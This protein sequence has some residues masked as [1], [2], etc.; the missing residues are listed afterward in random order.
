MALILCAIRSIKYWDVRKHGTYF[1]HDYPSPL[2]TS[3]YTPITRRAHGMTSMALS[4][5][6]RSLFALSSDNNIYMYNTTVLGHPV[7][8]FG[9]CDFACSSYYIKIS[10]SP[11]GNYIA[12]GSS[13]D[14]YV[15][16]INR[17]QKRPLIF[18]GHEREVT[19]VDWA[20]D[21]GNGTEVRSRSSKAAFR[22]LSTSYFYR[23]V[24]ITNAYSVS[25]Q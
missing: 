18:Q 13:K 14:L 4:P 15:W 25:I 1:K 5:D 6:G 7:E 2:Q 23:D 22:T 24:T 11:D 3:K 8:R 21:L 10:V 9:A 19:G 16:E 12:A 17:P 20:K